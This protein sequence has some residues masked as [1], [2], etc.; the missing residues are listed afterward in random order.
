MRAKRQEGERSNPRGG[1]W[2]CEK[3]TFLK[4]SSK[5]VAWPNI[6]SLFNPLFSLLT[7]FI[8]KKRKGDVFPFLSQAQ[9]QYEV[10]EKR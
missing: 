8:F 6:F 7:L 9:D 10:L 2:A 5:K 1:A 3:D 4:N